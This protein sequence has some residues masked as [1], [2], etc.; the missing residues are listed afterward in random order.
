[1]PTDPKNAF[2][3]SLG[4]DRSMAYLSGWLFSAAGGLCFGRRQ[5]ETGGANRSDRRR[6][7]VSWSKPATSAR[8]MAPMA[9]RACRLKRGSELGLRRT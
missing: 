7:G 4:S 6:Y 3:E 9:R 1:M 5:G 2:L 8:L